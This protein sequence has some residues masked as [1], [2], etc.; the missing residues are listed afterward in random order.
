LLSTIDA[1]TSSSKWIGYE[2]L[3]SV[4][5]GMAIQQG[6][7]A[8]QIV[9]PLNE[10]AIGT[11][12]VV[13]FQ[14]LGGEIFVSVGNTILQNSLLSAGHND[15]LPGVDVQAVISAGAS[16]FRKYV[17]AEQ[18]PALIGVY[19]KALQKVFIAAIP[20]AGLAMISALF[21]EWRKVNDKKKGEDE[22]A[23][24]QMEKW[25]KTESMILEANRKSGAP[26]GAAD[27]PLEIQ[28]E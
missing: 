21:L 11:A 18:L 23:S 14:S 13:A 8:V 4:G 10:V 7:T 15:M 27:N 26:A 25:K 1:T 24:K 16:E 6:F 12:A 2:I 20:M 9:L 5:I 22:E 3:A 17:T 28:R 19:N